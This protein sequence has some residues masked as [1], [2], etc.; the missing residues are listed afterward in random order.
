MKRCLY[1]YDVVVINDR[2]VSVHNDKKYKLP[3]GTDVIDGTGKWLSP[4]FVDAHVHFFQS[5]GLYARPDAVDLRKYQ[6]YDKELKF[7]HDNMDGLLDR[8]MAMGITTVIDVGASFNF[9]QQRD[10][11]AL[12][13]ASPVISMTGPLLTTWLPAPIKTLVMKAHLH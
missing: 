9:L 7:V 5:G 2:I 6:P 11:L 13:P 8:Y 10:S 12:G 3:A 1:G 4:G